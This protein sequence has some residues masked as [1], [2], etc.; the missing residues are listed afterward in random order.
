MTSKEIPAESF[1]KVPV[2]QIYT[3]GGHINAEHPENG[4]IPI[5]KLIGFLECYLLDLKHSALD[6]WED[7][8]NEDSE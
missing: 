1:E 7:V 3:Q 8:D 5:Y 2:L 6:Q 4:T